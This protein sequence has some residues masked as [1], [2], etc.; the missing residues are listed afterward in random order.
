[1]Q[2]HIILNL[3][4]IFLDCETNCLSLA[5]TSTGNLT[6][7]RDNS[8]N[9]QQESFGYDGLNRLTSFAGFN[10]QYDVKGNITQKSDA[11]ST[12]YYETLRRAMVF[13]IKRHARTLHQVGFW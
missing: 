5:Q 12:F 10:V 13:V 9:L 11:G 8:R 1:M 2:F 4:F 3:L 6:N 7:R